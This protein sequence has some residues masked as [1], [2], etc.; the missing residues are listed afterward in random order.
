[1]PPLLQSLTSDAR[2]AARYFARHKATTA[3][4]VAVLTLATG[5]N[6]LFF[7]LFQAQFLRP[8]PMVPDDPAHALVWMQERPTPTASW[9]LTYLTGTQLAQ[10]A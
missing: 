10:F 9:D 5:A 3:I 7:S 6:I 2:F 4:I 8:A 1:M